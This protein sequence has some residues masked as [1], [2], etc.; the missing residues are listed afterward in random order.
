MSSSVKYK[1]VDNLSLD[2]VGLP[3]VDVVAVHLV[4]FFWIGKGY[5]PKAFIKGKSLNHP[6]TSSLE[7]A[8]AVQETEPC[9]WITSWLKVGCGW[10]VALGIRVSGF[11]L[12]CFKSIP[13]W[14]GDVIMIEN[15][16]EPKKGVTKGLKPPGQH[17]KTND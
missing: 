1:V 13:R 9:C 5:H 15:D 3:Q 11:E 10:L 8:Q 2:H 6:F 17:L 14:R 16:V 12:F 4:I 7:K